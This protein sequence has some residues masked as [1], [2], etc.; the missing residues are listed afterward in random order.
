[1]SGVRT[2][3]VGEHQDIL[4]GLEGLDRKFVGAIARPLALAAADAGGGVHEHA[5]T[6]VGS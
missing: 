3:V 5:D 1:M 2:A 6:V 4:E